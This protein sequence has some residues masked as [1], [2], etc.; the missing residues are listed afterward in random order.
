MGLCS[1][2]PLF[3]CQCASILCCYCCFSCQHQPDQRRRHHRRRPRARRHRKRSAVGDHFSPL[4]KL[5]NRQRRVTTGSQPAE[6]DVGVWRFNVSVRSDW[7]E[8]QPMQA[9][10]SP[11]LER[12]SASVRIVQSNTLTFGKMS[13]LGTSTS[14]TKSVEIKDVSSKSTS[15]SPTTRSSLRVKDSLTSS[16]VHPH[17]GLSDF[18]NELGHTLHRLRF[19]TPV[20]CEVSYK[21]NCPPA[22]RLF[23]PTDD[24]ATLYPP[25]SPSNLSIRSTQSIRRS[26]FAVRSCHNVV[27]VSSLREKSG[28]QSQA[29]RAK[30]SIGLQFLCS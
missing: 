5:F 14:L 16:P 2:L 23:I 18:W 29:N 11:L 13:R 20:M 24:S 19:Q 25:P 9:E 4:R 7:N 12:N 27:R 15:P 28:T 26:P 8:D 3:K 21:A 30:S 22:A 6:E 10:I 1:S 17:P